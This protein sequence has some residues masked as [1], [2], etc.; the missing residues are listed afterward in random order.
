[1]HCRRA[2]AP[3][4]QLRRAV[5]QRRA[6]I[7]L[8]PFPFLSFTKEPSPLIE[9]CSRCFSSS[10]R[11]YAARVASLLTWARHSSL[12]SSAYFV[13]LRAQSLKLL[14]AVPSGVAKL[15]KKCGA[16]ATLDELRKRARCPKRGQH[17]QK[18][19]SVSER[20]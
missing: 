6:Q 11:A 17:T 15:F 20:R 7:P 9:Q 8:L 10:S 4:K 3:S 5:I 2:P 1:M 18:L 19:R 16:Y 14:R 13:E 12:T